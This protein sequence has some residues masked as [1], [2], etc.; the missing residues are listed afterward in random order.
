[1]K[2][3]CG[4]FSAAGS[5][6]KI[7]EY[8]AGRISSKIN[9]IDFIKN[10][11]EN[12]QQFKSDDVLVIAMPVFSGRLPKVCPAMI[13][14]LQGDHTP[15]ICLVAFGNRDYDDALLELNDLLIEQ[16]FVPIAAAA[17]IGEHSIFPEVAKDR[18]DKKDF[19]KLQQFMDVVNHKLKTFDG[20]SKD[21]QIKG[22]R[23]YKKYGNIPLK[24]SGDKKCNNCNKCVK[25]CPTHSI[26]ASNPRKTN[27]TTCISCTACIAVCPTGARN[28]D[29]IAYP[30][31]A[32]GF[33][34]KNKTYQ[35]PTWFI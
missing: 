20:S 35:E 18:P 21:L 1:M 2:T 4:Y 8:A 29:K 11:P 31:A 25:I 33:A 22:S 28:F 27:N 26:E 32:K 7:A 23:P 19:K 10:P 6:K 15:A 5:T 16:N 9:L 17:F 13:K 34:A 30:I 14:Q 12:K 24:P 3:Y